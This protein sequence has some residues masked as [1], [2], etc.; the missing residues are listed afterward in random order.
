MADPLPSHGGVLL[1]PCERANQRVAGGFG[2]QR[3]AAVI[4]ATVR[5]LRQERAASA[6]SVV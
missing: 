6:L 3:L 1:H 5:K 4:M 2:L